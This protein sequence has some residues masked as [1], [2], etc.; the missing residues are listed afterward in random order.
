MIASLAKRFLFRRTCC[1]YSRARRGCHIE[2]SSLTD[3]VERAVCAC[4]L[5]CFLPVRCSRRVVLLVL[6]NRCQHRIGVRC[7]AVENQRTLREHFGRIELAGI[8]RVDRGVGDFEPGL[9]L[10]PLLSD[11]SRME[12]SSLRR[13]S[14]SSQQQR[15]DRSWRGVHGQADRRAGRDRCNV[16]LAEKKDVCLSEEV[17]PANRIVVLVSRRIE[18]ATTSRR[19]LPGL[20]VFMADWARA[21]ENVARATA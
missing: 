13:C 3:I 15:R 7:V 1:V 19:S 12:Q 8:Q 5:E 14:T 4:G 21:S 9:L 16:W 17:R 18:P 11:R 10:A 20:P 6:R 2:H